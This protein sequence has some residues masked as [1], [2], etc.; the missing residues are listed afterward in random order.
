MNGHESTSRREAIRELIR[1]HRIGTQE[2]LR[3]RLADV[4]FD[5][6]QATLSRDLARLRA[7]RVTMAEGGSVYEIE[8]FAAAIEEG[9][10]ERV[11][12]MV[13][14]VLAGDS[15]VVVHT[16]PGAA[17][18]V[19]RAVDGAKLPE[20]LGTIAGDDTIFLAPARRTSPINLVNRLVSVWKKGKS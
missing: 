7:R 14:A 16:L 2:E 18:A 6:T 19:A 8:G 4:G 20:I 11:R 17:S 13:S 9:E 15:L 10:L 12:D 5:V 1:A 3:Q